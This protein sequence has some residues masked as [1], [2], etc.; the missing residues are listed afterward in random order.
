MSEFQQNLE[1]INV[2]EFDFNKIKSSIKEFFRSKEE[3]K[4]FDFDG[5]GL[6]FLLDILA[7]NTHQNAIIAHLGVNESFIDSAQLRASVVSNAKLLGYLPKSA[8]GSVAIINLE[9]RIENNNTTVPQRLFLSRGSRFTTKLDNETISFFTLE[10]NVSEERIENSNQFIYKFSNISIQ[11]G[12]LK[13]ITY[14]KDSDDF[15]QRFEIPDSSANVFEPSLRINVRERANRERLESYTRFKELIGTT[16]TSRIFFIQEN[17]FNNYEIFFGDGNTGREL[18][19]GDVVEIEYLYTEDKIADGAR[20]FAIGELIFRNFDDEGFDSIITTVRQSSG[21]KIKE[22]I[23]SIRF[24]APLSFITQNRAVTADDYQGLILR[25]FTD[26]ID[27][28]SVWGGEN[29]PIPEYGKVFISVKPRD[30]DFLS[31]DQKRIIEAILRER[32][33]LTILPEFEDPDFTF[34][35]A[36]VGFKFDPSQT[37][38]SQNE[39]ESFVINVINKFNDNNLKK[40]DGVF[41]FSRFLS[42]I[43]QSERSILSTAANIR[44]FKEFIIKGNTLENV[45]ELLYSGPIFRGTCAEEFVIQSSIFFIG[46]E[47]FFI[48][49]G[50]SITGT[51]KDL[52]LYKLT[53]GENIKTKK[54]GT[55]DITTGETKIFDLPG[56]ATRGDQKINLFAVPA[57]YDISPKRNQLLDIRSINVTG[58]I[59]EIAASGVSGKDRFTIKRRN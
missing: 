40:F 22:G 58:S 46:N 18:T 48:G 31:E 7:Y 59:D 9:I 45:G 37:N 51:L 43:D 2:S 3:Y 50:Q 21:A 19:I 44:M 30:A 14:R 13:K 36:D 17:P 23:E 28:I 47:R 25:E 49:D 5:A 32:N 34:I 1:P 6:S 20:N 52:F 35:E 11:N 55:S 8:A 15:N 16:S 27:T 42:D 10:D 38:L 39:L 41:R 57:S 56:T 33:I 53:L 29:Q 26:P 12:R 4:D 24:N 54:V